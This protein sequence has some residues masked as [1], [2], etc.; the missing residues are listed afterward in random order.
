METKAMGC[1][2]DEWGLRGL[3]CLVIMAFMYMREVLGR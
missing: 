1:I 3:V 2:R